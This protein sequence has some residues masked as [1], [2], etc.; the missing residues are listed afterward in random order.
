M[1]T[2]AEHLQGMIERFK[3]ILSP[4]DLEALG[5]AAATVHIIL[6]RTFSDQESMDLRNYWN[7]DCNDLTPVQQLITKQRKEK[8]S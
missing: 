2:R 1:I 6:G 5:Q 3:S 7:K 8:E 4:Q